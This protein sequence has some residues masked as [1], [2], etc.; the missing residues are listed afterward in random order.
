M[1]TDAVWAGVN[2][3]T[4]LL[5]AWSPSM[6]ALLMLIPQPS[7]RGHK[8]KG[9]FQIDEK[10]RLKRGPGP[11]Y[12]GLQIIRPELLD[13]IEEASFSMNVVW[14]IL[15]QR[16]ALNGVIYDGLWCDVGQPDSIPIAEAMLG[17]TAGV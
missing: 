15:M 6:E 12:S 9:D 5:S 3:I 11:I 2:P 7:A 1:N 17:E 10:G 4:Q 13:H 16:N 14:D 8:G